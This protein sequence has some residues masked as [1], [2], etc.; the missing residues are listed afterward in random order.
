MKYLTTK[1][2]AEKLNYSSDAVIRTLIQRK[3]INAEKL[4]HVW[5]IPEEEI[6]NIKR[7]RKQ[8]KPRKPQQ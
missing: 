3:Q 6:K 8:Y 7:V 5:M 1:E 4:G 2:A